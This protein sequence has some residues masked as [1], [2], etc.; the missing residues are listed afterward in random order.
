M[1]TCISAGV[2]FD[3]LLPGSVAP[4]VSSA[5]S[6]AAIPMVW[7]R[8]LF[9]RHTGSC[10]YSGENVTVFVGLADSTRVEV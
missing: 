6:C 2:E 7:R 5:R 10:S 9:V 8:V 1:T 4:I 3:L